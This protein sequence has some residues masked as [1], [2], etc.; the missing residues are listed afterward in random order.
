MNLAPRNLVTDAWMLL[1]AYWLISA[2]NLKRMK[3]IAPANVR[4][5][6]LIFLV[7][8]CILLF[9]DS[10]RVGLLRIAVLPKTSAIAGLGVTVTFMGI[11]FAIWARYC[12]GSNWSSQVAIRENHELIQSG[13][14]RWIRHPIYT[15]IIIGAWG[16]AIVAG[17]LGAFLG[18]IL[19]TLGLAY[20]GKQE[21]LNLRALFGDSWSAHAQRTGMFLPRMR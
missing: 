5:T 18:V 1:M 19:I 10:L 6:Q 21:E 9:A 4:F 8:G 3:Y 13:P 11:A 7:P 16:T 12:L 20:K 17:Q 14:Y 15:G 2:W